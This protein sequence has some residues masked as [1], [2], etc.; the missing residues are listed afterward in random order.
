ML[1]QLYFN[2]VLL[3]DYLKFVQPCV[4]AVNELLPFISEVPSLLLPL[5]AL[6]DTVVIPKKNGI[7]PPLGWKFTKHALSYKVRIFLKN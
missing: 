2:A 5:M 1:S 3:L 7:S 4:G 6:Q